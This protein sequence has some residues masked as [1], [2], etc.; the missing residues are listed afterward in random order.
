TRVRTGGLVM[1]VL[2]AE[3]DRRAGEDLGDRG[4]RCERRAHDDMDAARALEPVPHPGG[5]RPGLRDGA[6]HLPV[7]D[8]EWCSHP[9]TRAS[10]GGAPAP[11]RP[12]ARTPSI[13]APRRAGPPP[14]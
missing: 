4:E 5:E 3:V 1:A 10:A 8:D 6:V 2:G 13:G 11:R 12:A 14:R 9:I 7:A